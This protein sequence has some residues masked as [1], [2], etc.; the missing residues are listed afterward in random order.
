MGD[1]GLARLRSQHPLSPGARPAKSTHKDGATI[2]SSSTQ[3]TQGRLR[4]GRPATEVAA[5]GAKR[6]RHTYTDALVRTLLIR[7]FRPRRFGN[8]VQASPVRT[9]LAKCLNQVLWLRSFLGSMP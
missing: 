2:S 6:P 7:H 4:R 8:G 9:K 3:E 5:K 1:A